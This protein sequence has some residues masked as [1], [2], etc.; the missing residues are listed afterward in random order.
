VLPPLPE[1]AAEPLSSLTGANGVLPPTRPD[2]DVKQRIEGLK[3]R[4]VPVGKPT[5]PVFAYDENEPLRVRPTTL[6][7]SE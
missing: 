3:Q 2:P 1:E 5:K 7:K 6:K 4:A